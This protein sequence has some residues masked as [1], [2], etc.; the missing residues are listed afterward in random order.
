M[1]RTQILAQITAEIALLQRAREIL[2][3]VPAVSKKVTRAKAKK[4]I[5]PGKKKPATIVAAVSASVSPVTV[6]PPP[7]QPAEQPP[8]RRVPPK[9]RM[10]RRQNHRP[11]GSEKLGKLPAALSGFVPFGPVV[12]SADEAR[13]VQERSAPP[14]SAPVE[15]EILSNGSERSFGS[16]VQAFERRSG[17][18]GTR[19]SS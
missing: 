14:P 2:A 19:S 9:R 7:P 13:K 12:V 6:A 4:R 11:A 18:S 8:V 3:G 15:N 10:E 1:T 5:S 17:L 16:L